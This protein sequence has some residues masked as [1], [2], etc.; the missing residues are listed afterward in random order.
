MTKFLN[1][2]PNYTPFN[3]G[4]T[5]TISFESFVFSGGEPHIRIFYPD[6]HID[7]ECVW[8]THRINSM[9]D[10][11]LLLVAVNSLKGY[12]GYLNTSC[13]LKLFVPYFPGARQDR[14]CNK[15]EALTVKVYSEI[16]NSMGFDE[17][18]IYDPHSD[19]VTALV[20]NCRVIDN[21]RFVRHCIKSIG[22]ENLKI[23]SPD[24]GSNKKIGALCKSLHIDSYVR[25]DKTRDL[26][27]GSIS[28]FEVYSDDLGGKDCVIVD[29]ICDG[30][31]T[32]V[33]LA[34]ELKKKNAGNL[35]LIVSHGIFS[36][37]FST[38]K[39][40]FKKIYTTD[41]WTSD[42]SGFQV[43]GKFEKDFIEI[44]KYN[45]L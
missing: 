22:L 2:T 40:D 33:G 11:G 13:L 3:H 36:K 17:V 12:H 4:K 26:L 31:G 25:C 5:E 29:D 35:Y 19:V 44:I 14:V 37:G 43:Y 42:Y 15:G 45:S 6:W 38:L 16:I 34:K 28:G 20:D 30:G 27:S 8:I 23:I 1:L 39:K 7:T 41:S 32:F 21:H 24:A 9:N 10:L 18:V